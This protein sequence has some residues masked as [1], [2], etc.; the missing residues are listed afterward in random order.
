MRENNVKAL[1]HP[2]KPHY[3]RGMCSTCYQR[4]LYRKRLKDDPRGFKALCRKQR[5]EYAAKVGHEEMARR[6]AAAGK[7]TRLRLR[8]EMFAAYGNKCSCCG[9]SEIEFLTLEHINNDGAAHKRE[10]RGSGYMIWKDLKLRGWPKEAYTLLC[11]NCNCAR[12]KCG[13]CPH[14]EIARRKKLVGK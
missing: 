14:K 7:K 1:C 3:A 6:R 11:Y 10:V 12:Y 2:E 4:A 9:E 5:V 8:A 13:E